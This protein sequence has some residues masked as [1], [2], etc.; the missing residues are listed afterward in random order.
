MWDENIATF[1]HKLWMF[2]DVHE[3]N[4]HSLTIYFFKNTIVDTHVHKKSNGI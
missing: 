2:I 4:V 3:W 1:G